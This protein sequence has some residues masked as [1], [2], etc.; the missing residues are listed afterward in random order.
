M[1][2]SH[3]LVKL[4]NDQV[5]LSERNKERVFERGQIGRGS[6][7]KKSLYLEFL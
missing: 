3:R 1:N 4:T 7:R 2:L 5:F 6:L